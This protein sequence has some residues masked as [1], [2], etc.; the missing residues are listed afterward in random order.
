ML[1]FEEV[2]EFITAPTEIVGQKENI[3]VEHGTIFL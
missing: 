3:I 1:S 2:S